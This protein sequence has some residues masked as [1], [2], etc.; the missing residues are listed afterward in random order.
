ME[1]EQNII[2]SFVPSSVIFPD[3]KPETEKEY[4]F[5][6]E[7][8]VLGS[9][10][11][12]RKL[13]QARW[14]SETGRKWQQT[15]QQGEQLLSHLNLE[16]N[17][18]PIKERILTGCLEEW[19]MATL[20]F[21]LQNFGDQHPQKFGFLSDVVQKLKALRNDLSHH[22]SKSLKKEE[23]N[24]KVDKFRSI[25][26]GLDVDE[27]EIE[28]MIRLAGVTDSIAAKKIMKARYDEAKQC[29]EKNEGAKGFER[30]L[31]CFDKA[32]STPSLLRTQQA[33]AFEKRA[34]CYLQFARH[35]KDHQV[36]EWINLSNKAIQDARLATELNDNS[37]NA[38]VIM[39]RAHRLNSNWEEAVNHLN[40]TLS[41]CPSLQKVEQ[42]LNT[43]KIIL[44]LKN[45][46]GVEGDT[47]DP[48]NPE[49]NKRV[50]H[51][52]RVFGNFLTEQEYESSLRRGTG[53]T[54]L[55]GQ[56]QVYQGHQHHYGWCPSPSEMEAV[57]FYTKAMMDDN[58][59]G[60]LS[61][62]LCLF[63]GI[64]VAKNLEKGL[65]LWKQVAE[66]PAT[67]RG[68]MNSE[69][70]N[71]AVVKAQCGLGWLFSEGVVDDAKDELKENY[72]TTE[73]EDN[74]EKEKD[75]VLV[76]KDLGMAAEWFKKAAENGSGAAAN[77]LANLY[78]SGSGS[79]KDP[80][81]GHHYLNLA[82]KLGDPNG[83]AALINYYLRHMELDKA[84][85]AF[86][87]GK[88]VGHEALVQ[89]EDDE[90]WAATEPRADQRKRS[91]E[92][93]LRFEKENGLEDDE[94]LTFL[95][96]LKRK[97]SQVALPGKNTKN[98][99][100]EKPQIP[101][102]DLSSRSTKI[103]TCN[104]DSTSD[105]DSAEI[106]QCSELSSGIEETFDM[107]GGILETK[108][109]LASQARRVL[110]TQHRQLIS[111][112]VLFN[113]DDVNADLS[114]FGVTQ[115]PPS[116]TPCPPRTLSGVSPIFLKEM[117]LTS[118]HIYKDRL[119]DL[120]VI[121]VPNFKLPMAHLIVEDLNGDVTLLFLKQ[122]KCKKSIIEKLNFGRKI[123]ILNP[124]MQIRNGALDS[125]E[126]GLRV[127]DPRCLICLGMIEEMCRFC[128]EKGAKRACS[129][130]KEAIYCGKECELRDYKTMKHGKICFAK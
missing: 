117:E 78:F 72:Q 123:A 32:V 90:F 121:D 86:K 101:T 73:E 93:V 29:L 67:V 20:S 99:V 10:Y 31:K 128:G 28:K 51:W 48:S 24:T 129:K 112:M 19:D 85:E 87:K 118:D 25:V 70:K 94:E 26:K 82:V 52:D 55:I 127:D 84:F 35:Q 8:M 77:A 37:W 40:E 66:S 130:C 2:M 95:E 105:S 69:R 22:P 65:K 15:K 62:A 5:K 49:E 38:H 88:E 1:Q 81:Q 36:P 14:T 89:I 61:V 116:L 63:D 68:R 6:V 107:E 96:R 80:K 39:A 122:E 46:G 114:A 56:D 4:Y 83:A 125:F 109:H 124:Y 64:G 92:D 11:F 45:G 47:T 100:N 79:P 21:V 44:N 43:C 53:E 50:S 103:K 3:L 104:S 13:F 115:H 97:R 34:E 9:C 41:M 57:R 7:N 75:L 42:E 102:E 12:L 18:E 71:D 106:S 30:A 119:I 23:Y 60:M 113:K 108:P 98:N 110:I 54:S 91:E 58:V 111:K 33:S 126:N 74:K 59:E 76:K 27:E 120:T 17:I 16:V